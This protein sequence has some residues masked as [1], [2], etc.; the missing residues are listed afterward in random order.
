MRFK[1]HKCST[2]EK[3]KMCNQNVFEDPSEAFLLYGKKSDISYFI[4]L[5]AVFFT[6]DTEEHGL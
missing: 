1:I 3:L 6:V 4:V 2:L 5:I